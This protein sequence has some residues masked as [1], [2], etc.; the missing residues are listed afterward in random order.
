MAGTAMLSSLEGSAQERTNPLFNLTTDPATIR[1]QMQRALPALERGVQILQ[2][3]PDAAAAT[4]GV[5][6]LYD[7]YRYLRA[8]Q[9]SSAQLN[10]HRKF[11]DPVVDLRNERVWKVRT[12]L[13][14]C[15]GNF[16]PTSEGSIAMCAE[17]AAAA[18]RELRV[19]FQV[20]P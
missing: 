4:K 16:V 8:A 7:S 10:N 3:S 11:P 19:I 5:E 1:T 9:E 17:E 12:R 2:A 18:L 15:H 6:A 14:K 13:I 20:F